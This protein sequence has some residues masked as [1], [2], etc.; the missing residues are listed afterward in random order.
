MYFNQST[1]YFSF[2]IQGHKCSKTGDVIKITKEQGCSCIDAK[3]LYGPERG[4]CIEGRDVGDGGDCNGY[5]CFR[6][7]I[8]HPLAYAIHEAGLLPDRNHGKHVIDPNT[9]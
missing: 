4:S 7:D 3:V 9:C 1:D 6:L 5:C 8:R 2:P